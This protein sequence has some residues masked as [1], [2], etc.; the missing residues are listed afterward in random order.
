VA[1]VGGLVVPVVQV[2]VFIADCGVGE[3]RG[4]GGC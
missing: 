2:A 1:L 4:H 3:G